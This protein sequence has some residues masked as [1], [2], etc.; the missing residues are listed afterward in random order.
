MSGGAG[1]PHDN[2]DPHAPPVR[3]R[4]LP[5]P[6]VPSPPAPPPPPGLRAA[7]ASPWLQPSSLGVCLALSPELVPHLFCTDPASRGQ[8]HAVLTEGTGALTLGCEHFLPRTGGLPPTPMSGAWWASPLLIPS[9]LCFR[10][11]GSGLTPE[12]GMG[13]GPRDRPQAWGQRAPEVHT[14]RRRVPTPCP[15]MAWARC[16]PPGGCPG[17]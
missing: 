3:L 8:G 2:W 4:A 17:I 9:P 13:S 15:P 14:P 5:P 7:V 6:P 1:V 12:R 10:K 11:A 16:Q